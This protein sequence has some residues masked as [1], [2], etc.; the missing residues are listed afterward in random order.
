MTLLA[1][2]KLG[3]YELLA[4][5]G[6]G[7]MGEVYRARDTR[8]GREVAVKVL[9]A[10]FSTD[11]DRLRRFEQEARAASAL[12]HPNILS[13]HDVGTHQGAPYVVSELLEGETLRERLA[14]AALSTRKAVDYGV[15]IAEG[16]AAAHEKGIVHRD[17][18]PENL[19]VTKDGRVKILDFGLAKLVLAEAA[20]GSRTDVPTVPAG[21]EP[22]VVM[23]T[24]GYMSPEQVRGLTVDARSDIFSFGAVLYE[25]ASG[26]R[27][28]HAGSAVETMN[29]VL[30]EDPLQASGALGTFSASL[31]RVTRRCLEK[32]PEERFQSA[33]DLAFALEEV[34]ASSGLPAASARRRAPA[35]AKSLAVLPLDNTSG[36]PD[37]DYLGDGIAESLIRGLSRVPK[38]RVMAYSSV[39]KYKGR[40]PR[41]A[42][43]DLGVDAVLAGRVAQRGDTL[44]IGVELVDVAAGWQLWGEQ[45]HRRLM[46]V[47][48]VQGEI[49]TEISEKLRLQLT[50][51]SRK[52]IVKRHTASATAY[53]L[54]LKGRYCWNKRTPEGLARAIGFFNEAIEADPAYALAY[55]GVADSYSLLPAYAGVPSSEGYPKARAAALKALEL[56]G[57][58]AD[59]YLPLAQA[60]L[61]YD[62]DWPGAEKEYRQA[63]TLNPGWASAHHFLAVQLA[64]LGRFEE[65]FL[66]YGRAQDLDPLSLPISSSIGWALYQ[67]RQYDRAIEQCKKT[68]EMDAGFARAHLYLGEIYLQRGDYEEAIGQFEKGIALSGE[69]LGP[70]GLAHAFAVSGRCG[71]A[72]QMLDEFSRERQRNRVSPFHFAVIHCGLGETD[73]AFEWLERAYAERSTWIPFLL[74]EPRI[75]LLL[76]DPRFSE[77]LRRVN[78]SR[79]R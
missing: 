69:S 67:S 3:P 19:F 8:L 78:L 74:S 48:E 33:R 24:V 40:D 15:Q 65:A 17:L 47:L 58:L 71:E 22:G 1:G 6:A 18:K 52:R 79:D 44:T 57:T 50:E 60:K 56:D 31:E 12:N 45:Y 4:P 73:R 2:T 55:A 9:P 30:K 11:A 29:A 38:L 43:R 37:T 72:R 61:Y 36:N 42:G 77:L 53:Q 51:R 76:G 13:I 49:A 27:A 68:L 63:I 54:Y 25:M 7:G 20:T 14:G 66:E 32:S 46:D 35:R 34:S 23:G 75:D 16:L 26:R 59:A 39:S 64:L 28:F 41:Q 21:T 10:A 62:W 5:L 70:V